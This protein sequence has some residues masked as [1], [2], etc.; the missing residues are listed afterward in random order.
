MNEILLRLFALLSDFGLPARN[1]YLVYQPVELI[2]QGTS[3]FKRQLIMLGSHSVFQ[4]NCP[5]QYIFHVSHPF[6]V[7][8][9]LKKFQLPE[10]MCQTQL[11]PN[12][13]GL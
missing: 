5:G 3:L 10:Q 11:R 8:Q 6:D 1:H 4:V 13:R 2:E 9:L 12:S 7:A